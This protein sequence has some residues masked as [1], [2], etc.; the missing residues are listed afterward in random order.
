MTSTLLLAQGTIIDG[1]ERG[2]AE[3]K[4]DACKAA[5]ESAKKNYDV[6]DINVGCNC[7]I[8]DSRQWMCFVRF[9][10]FVEDN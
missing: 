10:H 3:I 5:K 2:E 8:S 4:R 6:R 7:E 9:K 1:L